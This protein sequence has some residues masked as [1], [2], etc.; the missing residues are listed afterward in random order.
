MRIQPIDNHHPTTGVT[1]PEGNDE[2]FIQS[3]ITIT[4]LLEFMLN[5]CSLQYEFYHQWFH[6]GLLNLTLSLKTF[7]KM[8]KNCI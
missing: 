6:Y 4:Q 7:S 8:Q 1:K 3:L 5:F 2:D